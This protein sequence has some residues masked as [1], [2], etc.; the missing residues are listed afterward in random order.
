MAVQDVTLTLGGSQR[1]AELLD[2]IC[3]LYD[4][5]FSVPGAGKASMR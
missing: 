3:A 5:V 2:P 4:A 1:A